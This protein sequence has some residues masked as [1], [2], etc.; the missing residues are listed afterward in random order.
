MN[1]LLHMSANIYIG[2]NK[3]DHNY[4]IWSELAKG[5]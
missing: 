4:K 3:L 2:I 5:F 1:N